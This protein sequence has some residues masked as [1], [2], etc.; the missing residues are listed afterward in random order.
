MGVEDEEGTSN[1]KNPFER[2][3]KLQTTRRTAMP[4]RAHHET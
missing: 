4:H 1:V 3:P 2:T